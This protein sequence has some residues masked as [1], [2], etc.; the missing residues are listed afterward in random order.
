MESEEEYAGE[1]SDR[2]GNQR[3]HLSEQVFVRNVAASD[4]VIYPD[5]P[6]A[7]GSALATTVDVSHCGL[8]LYLEETVLEGG[9]LALWVTLDE[10]ADPVL[11]TGSVRWSHRSGNG[12]LVGVK[13]DESHEDDMAAWQRL[14]QYKHQDLSSD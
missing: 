1:K 2:R 5:E 11:L 9:T 4:I 13:L 3:L 12:F 14:I 7:E 6:D 10:G 8:R